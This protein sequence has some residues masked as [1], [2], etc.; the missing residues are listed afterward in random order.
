MAA[1]FGM[2]LAEVPNPGPDGNAADGAQLRR[3]LLRMENLRIDVRLHRGSME[4]L[5]GVSFRIPPGKTVALVGESGSG[6]TIAAQAILGILPNVARVTGGRILFRPPGGSGAEFD[7]AC[8]PPGGPY[9]RSMRG[10]DISMI[11]QEPMSSLSPLHRIGHQVEEALRLHRP[12]KGREAY[13]TTVDMLRLVG[14]P[15]PERSYWRYPAEL[16]GGMRQRAMIAMAVICQPSLLIADEPTTALDVTIQAQVLSLLR[17]LQ[18][19][20]SMSLL[21]ITHDFGIVANMADEIIVLYHGEVME[22]GNRQDIF[23]RTG[24]A[25]TKALMKAVPSVDMEPGDRLRGLWE[26]D[27]SV[28]GMLKERAQHRKEPVGPILSVKGVTKSFQGRGR[29]MFSARSKPFVAVND[30]S[31]DVWPGECFGIVGESGCGKTTL[32][33]LVL[34]GLTC[35][36]GSILFDDGSGPRD[37]TRFDAKALFDYRRNAQMVFQD[38]FGSLNPRATILN[39][40]REPLEIHSACGSAEARRAAEELVRLVG[41][42]PT[43]LNRF[44]HSFSGGQRQRIG[45]ARAL[46]LSPRMLVCDEPVSALDVSVQAQILN[47]LK[48]LQ[49]ELRLTMLFISHNLAVIKYMADRL[50]VMRRGRIVELAPSSELFRSPRHPYTRQLLKAVPHADLDH[51]LPF[52]FFDLTCSDANTEREKDWDPV[53]VSAAG[54][55]ED[56]ALRQVSQSHFVLAREAAEL[57]GLVS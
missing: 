26:I 11:F 30:V 5:K 21:L 41:L 52:D 6:K 46:A 45:I 24:H 48:T 1:E 25:Y 40:L 50:A 42:Q 55:G 54:S 14:F 29:S 28:P 32:S 19:R 9:M 8:E 23:H 36:Q 35:D 16:S 2:G 56:L 51:P 7:H 53:F 34:R 15:D 13:E 10:G 18:E 20:L 49:A 17:N 3:D 4:V 38:P 31:F 39:I 22:A 33:K 44:P 12:V 27:A 37:V 47:L 57:E 43:I